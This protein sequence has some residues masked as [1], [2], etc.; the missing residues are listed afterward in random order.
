[1]GHPRSGSLMPHF[2]EAMSN[3][4]YLALD[5]L[6]GKRIDAW[7]LYR[8]RELRRNRKL[9]KRTPEAIDAL[10]T[11][12]AN[13]NAKSV[14]GD[15]KNATDLAL[16]LG[17]KTA[18]R[19][20]RAGGKPTQSGIQR[21]AALAAYYRDDD[22]PEHFP[23]SEAARLCIQ[24][25]P[26]SSHWHVVYAPISYYKHTAIAALEFVCTGI[27]KHLTE[28]RQA[29]GLEGK[30]TM[31]L[32]IGQAGLDDALVRTL[33]NLEPDCDDVIDDQQ[34]NVR[35][36]TLLEAGADPN[37][38][39]TS[40][41]AMGEAI[42]TLDMALVDALLSRGGKACHQ[43]MEIVLQGRIGGVEHPDDFKLQL[44]NA[45]EENDLF[46]IIARCYPPDFSWDHNFE[47]ENWEGDSMDVNMEQA[48]DNYAVRIQAMQQSASLNTN[49]AHVASKG[50]VRRI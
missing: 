31:P 43:D 25:A 28:R 49:T 21:L 16:W 41:R 35:V 13:P 37:A 11:Q 29:R 30:R 17:P 19:L 45:Q 18:E 50:T 38:T 2:L 9:L 33:Q 5:V 7:L 10:L 12:G 4:A 48:L 20:L 1:M 15:A 39:T 42:S 32:P 3:R 22:V 36:E 8:L 23:Y 44:E 34:R 40:G 46:S 27:I 47:V 26:E 14:L 24:A 6:S